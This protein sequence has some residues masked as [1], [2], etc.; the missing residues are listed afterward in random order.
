MAQFFRPYSYKAYIM[1][2]DQNKE[3]KEEGGLGRTN[4][5]DQNK[6]EEGSRQQDGRDISS[7]DQQEGEMNNGVI[8]RDWESGKDPNEGGRSDQSNS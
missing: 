6:D 8:G 1:E 2:R 4:F 3:R 5:I 7:I